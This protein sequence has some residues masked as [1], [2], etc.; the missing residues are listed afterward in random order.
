MKLRSSYAFGVLKVKIW[1]NIMTESRPRHWRWMSNL[2]F[3][4]LEHRLTYKKSSRSSFNFGA[5][6]CDNWEYIKLNL[7]KQLPSL[8]ALVVILQLAEKPDRPVKAI[9]NR[10][11][12][13]SMAISACRS[14]L[15]NEII[16]QRI[17]SCTTSTPFALV[18]RN[19]IGSVSNSF[20]CSRWNRTG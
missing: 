18:M 16:H 15:F 3:K 8:N 14:W 6:F 10:K 9:R 2:I 17:Y 5:S 4:A 19:A 1:T 11:N 7:S 13:R 12:K 20:L